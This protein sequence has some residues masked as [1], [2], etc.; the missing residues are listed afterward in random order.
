MALRFVTFSS[1]SPTPNLTEEKC[2]ERG[3]REY[4]KRSRRYM[5]KVTKESTHI[6]SE[7]KT[8]YFNE[9]LFQ[10]AKERK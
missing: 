4:L 10:P 5:Q 3:V 9:I 2:S 8:H 7:H 6:S 1:H